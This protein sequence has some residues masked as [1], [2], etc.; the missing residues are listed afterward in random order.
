M[1]AFLEQFSLAGKTAVVT[2]AGRG[3][4]P[5]NIHLVI[6]DLPHDYTLPETFQ[7]GHPMQDLTALIALDQVRRIIEETN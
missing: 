2:G 4:G 5:D 1:T 3:L 6:E 7:R